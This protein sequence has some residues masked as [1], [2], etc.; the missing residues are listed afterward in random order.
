MN[1]NPNAPIIRDDTM[2][3][4][5]YLAKKRETRLWQYIG[6]PK[7]Q[8][9]K[10]QRRWRLM[11]PA[12]TRFCDWWREMRETGCIPNSHDVVGV[13]VPFE[14]AQL[15]LGGY[16]NQDPNTGAIDGSTVCY[17]KVVEELPLVQGV[18]L[19]QLPDEIIAP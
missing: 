6:L 16:Y 5:R 18:T 4:I 12:T 3:N 7:R 14:T 15:L 17:G 10:E 19:Y 2:L 9:D 8:F 1:G 11:A 13:P